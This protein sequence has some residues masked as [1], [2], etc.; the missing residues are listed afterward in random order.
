MSNVR[1][2][3]PSEQT[4]DAT[5]GDARGA[6]PRPWWAAA[7]LVAIALNLRLVFAS[8]SPVLTEIIHDTG[9]SSAAASILTTAP[10]L[11]LGLCGLAAPRL[12]ERF[13]IE[14]IVLS[15]I[16]TL[17]AATA[18]RGIVS[19][20]ML[21]AG[22]VLAGA[23]IGIIGALIP[24]LVKRD[25]PD[26]LGPMMG[27]YTTSLCVSAAAGAGLTVPL[28]RGL[29]GGWPA[30]LAF[31]SVPAILAAAIWLPRLR[32]PPAP[33]ASTIG[34]IRGVWGEPLAWQVTL[35][36]GL[37]SS[38]A[39]I[40]FAWV[41]P[42]LRDRGVEPAAAGL[43]V[44]ISVIAQGVAALTAPALVARWANQSLAAALTMA[45]ALVGVLGWLYTPIG[46]IWLWAIVQGIG[47]GAAF[48]IGLTLI[49]LRSSD[50]YVAGRL[51][52][53]SQSGGYAVASAGPLALGFLHDWTGDWTAAGP[54]FV[55]I[56]LAAAMFGLLAGRARRIGAARRLR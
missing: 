6:A 35:Y 30:A 31:W 18:M 34:D 16:V 27:I 15:G 2:R 29:S 8:L 21:F 12:A 10:V 32:D 7:A 3:D 1:R 38:V 26:A 25:F 47:Q 54:L 44:S 55:A 14:R 46:L 53:M 4:R 43:A 50:M 40:I 9:I 5:T 51:S 19:F 17:A 52:S 28:E 42:I 56:A 20:P 39:Y 11:C 45:V 49:V 23:A 22:S 36:L 24:S 37:Q 41:A 33:V 13:G 48:A